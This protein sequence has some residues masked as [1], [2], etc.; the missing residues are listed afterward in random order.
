MP[1]VDFF[2]DCHH[3]MFTI[4][5][6]PLYHTI[7]QTAH[8]NLTFPKKLAIPVLFAF[9][10]P[11]SDAEKRVKKLRKFISFFES[12]PEENVSL[13]VTEVLKFIDGEEDFKPPFTVGENNILLTPL[14]MD[15]D[16][17]GGVKKL[18]GQIDHLTAAIDKVNPTRLK[19]LPFLGI[20]PRRTDADLPKITELLDMVKPLRELPG[21]IAAAQNGTFIGIKLYPPLGF[22]PRDHVKLCLDV[23]E[24]KIPITVHCQQSS[25]KLV[26]DADDLTDPQNWE[27]VLEAVNSNNKDLIINFAHFGGEDEV[28]KTIRFQPADGFPT[29]PPWTF[30][31]SSINGINEDTWTYRIISMLKKFDSAYSDLSAFD[32]SDG[33]AVAALQWLLHFD[34][35]G[36]LGKGKNMLTDKLLWGTDYPMTLM[37]GNLTYAKLFGDFVTAIKKTNNSACPYPPHMNK[38]DADE[39]I[40]KLVC[41]NPKRFLGL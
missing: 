10:L 8:D 15:L 28:A 17:G 20:D 3:H 26:N 39:F 22:N 7:R 5:D 32:F 30:D 6:I 14:V 33:T 12:Q 29:G 2:I 16:I 41:D 13:I 4:T 1:H 9:Y 35:E 38:F 25:L 36:V 21:G 18:R 34:R 37:D 40:R 27:P 24:K 23:A 31:G 11:V 19:V